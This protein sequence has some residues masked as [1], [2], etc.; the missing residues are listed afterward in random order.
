M[1]SATCFQSTNTCC[2]SSERQVWQHCH[3]N[4]CI[5]CLMHNLND[6]SKLSMLRRDMLIVNSMV[7]FFKNNAWTPMCLLMLVHTANW[8]T[9][10]TIS[11]HGRS[12]FDR[13][14]YNLLQTLASCMKWTVCEFKE[15]SVYVMQIANNCCDCTISCLY[16]SVML[17]Q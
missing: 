5:P 2:Q 16:A 13:M 3:A 8:C 7:A 15:V 14:M 17:T 9:L 11:S 10:E 1:K 6:E 4:D 12:F